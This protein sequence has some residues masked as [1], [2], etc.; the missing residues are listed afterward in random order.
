MAG[1]AAGGFGWAGQP[2]TPRLPSGYF[3][4]HAFSGYSWLKERGWPNLPTE[5]FAKS[6]SLAHFFA[7]R[8][9]N[10]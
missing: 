1:L 10:A 4:A 8:F 7:M 2:E 5:T 9:S 6:S 3:H